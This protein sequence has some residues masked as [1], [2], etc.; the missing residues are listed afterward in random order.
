MSERSESAAGVSRRAVLAGAAA[1]TASAMA[2]GASVQEKPSDTAGRGSEQ[3][4][5]RLGSHGHTFSVE[6][7]REVVTVLG[8]HQGR[9]IDWC[10]YGQPNPDGVCGTLVVAP[11]L[12]PAVITDL[13]NIKNLAVW[14]FGLFPKGT[15]IPDLLHIR[16]TGGRSVEGGIIIHG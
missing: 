10:Q 9:I 5:A 6:D 16:I 8:K 11:R 13:L 1:T 15:P 12:A 14:R 7:L 4:L 2:A 3:L